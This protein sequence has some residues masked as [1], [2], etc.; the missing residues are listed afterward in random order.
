MSS[1]SDNGELVMEVIKFPGAATTTK[2]LKKKGLKHTVHENPHDHPLI[3]G[4]MTLSCTNCGNKA[5]IEVKDMIFRT[6][7]YYCTSCGTKHR[8]TN[9]AFAKSVG[10]EK[11]NTGKRYDNR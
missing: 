9:P 4:P 8:I 7:E 3:I 2:R 11:S 10:S 5:S 1:I 6:L